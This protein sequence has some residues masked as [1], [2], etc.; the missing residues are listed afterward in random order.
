MLGTN[1]VRKEQ[2]QP[3]SAS[4]LPAFLP[5]VPDLAVTADN[6]AD[7]AVCGRARWKVENETFNVL[8]TQGYNLEHSFGHGKKTLANLLVSLNL[9]AFAFH[10]VANLCVL[11]WRTALAARRAKYR[12][13]EHLRT[14]TAYI[15]FPDWQSLLGAITD[16]KVR[17]L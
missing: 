11:A 14:I 9:L 5:Q 10:T 13:F 3:H 4:Y 6:V 1:R 16:P 7:L 2:M 8:K 17:P 15:V 12:F